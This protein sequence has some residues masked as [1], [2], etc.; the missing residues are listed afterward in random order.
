MSSA[1]TIPFTVSSPAS[2]PSNS[3]LEPGDHLTVEEFH[4]RYLLLPKYIKA[5][6]STP[7]PC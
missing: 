4:R 1:S 7:M 3:L 2:V 5:F 6:G